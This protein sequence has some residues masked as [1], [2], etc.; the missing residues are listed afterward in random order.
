MSSEVVDGVVYVEAPC[1]RCGIGMSVSAD[2]LRTADTALWPLCGRCRGLALAFTVYGEPEPRGSKVAGISKKGKRYYRDTNPASYP[3]MDDVKRAAAEAMV[4][5]ELLIGA[6]RVDLDFYLK[7]PKAHFGSGRNAAL[8][9]A[10]SPARP[11]VA[12]D[13]GKLERGVLDALEGIVYGNDAQ[14]VEGDSRKFY[15]NPT[16]CE[17][18]IT[19]L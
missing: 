5:R 16:R 12:P 7:R 14:V 19:A 15:G 9:K 1:V 11:I 3:W 13:K 4:D 10:S 2:G 18:R 6:V 8:V 17:I